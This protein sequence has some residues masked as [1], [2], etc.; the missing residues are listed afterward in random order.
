MNK[1][2]ILEGNKLIAEFMVGCE[3]IEGTVIRK[4]KYY[5]FPDHCS[6]KYLI[7]DMKFHSSW[8]WLMPVVEKIEPLSSGEFS[9][10]DFVSADIKAIWASCVIFIKWYNKNNG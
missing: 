5:N 9:L 4:T 3:I 2:E 6:T 7:S 8:D 1:K 10:H